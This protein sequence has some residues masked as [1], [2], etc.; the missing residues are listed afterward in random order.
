MRNRR[1]LIS[2]VAC[3]GAFFL[4]AGMGPADSPPRYLFCTLQGYGQGI[5]TVRLR[6]P[7]THSGRCEVDGAIPTTISGPSPVN[8]P[9]P[10]LPGSPGTY[11]LPPVHSSAGSVASI[12]YGQPQHPGAA[13]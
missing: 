2:L 9:A 7:A 1:T 3:A 12:I 8:Y 4:V 6:V 5:Y 13:P 11:I 10:F